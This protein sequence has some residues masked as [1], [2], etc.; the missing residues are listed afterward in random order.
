MAVFT[1]ST[2][3]AYLV[4]SFTENLTEATA[5][6]LIDELLALSSASGLTK[7]LIDAADHGA[8]ADAGAL[9][10]WYG[11]CSPHRTN[12]YH[13]G[14]NEQSSRHQS[15]LS[16]RAVHARPHDTLFSQTRRR[17]NVAL[18]IAW[19]G[20]LTNGRLWRL[21]HKD[22]AHKQDRFYEVD[23]PSLVEANDA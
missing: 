18:G 3:R 15:D 10:A 14:C 6:A 4:G 22:T 1:V 17:S 13:G 23:L 9:S 5:F 8:I 7:V 21:Y 20:I 16:N 2:D 11:P 19:R 12:V